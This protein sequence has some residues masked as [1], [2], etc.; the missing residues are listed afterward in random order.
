MSL[1]VADFAAV[2]LMVVLKIVLKVARL[3]IFMSVSTD[4]HFAAR[5]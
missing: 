3:N 2:V 4:G 5:L 1:I